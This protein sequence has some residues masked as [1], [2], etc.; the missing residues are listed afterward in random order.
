MSGISIAMLVRSVSMLERRMEIW[1]RHEAGKE[2]KGAEETAGAI[3]GDEDERTGEVRKM[4]VTS[5]LTH[6]DTPGR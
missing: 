5:S 3:E 1:T 6:D 2:N 4:L